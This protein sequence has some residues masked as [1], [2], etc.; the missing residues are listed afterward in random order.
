[1]PHQ[2][3]V[4]MG[5]SNS[6]ISQCFE[7]LVSNGKSISSS[8]SRINSIAVD[9][10][11]IQVQHVKIGSHYEVESES[12]IVTET[13]TVDVYNLGS[14]Q[15]SKLR[16]NPIRNVVK[17]VSQNQQ[18]RTKRAL[19]QYKEMEQK[20][21]VDDPTAYQLVNNVQEPLIALASRNHPT[22]TVTNSSACRKFLPFLQYLLLLLL[23]RL[24]NYTLF[25]CR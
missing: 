22:F 4:V 10:K 15:P 7:R 12:S 16:Q 19:K 3:L 17:W 13:R 21:K 14:I 25:Y 11:R 20:L 18:T 5:H 1:M 9:K 6:S 24:C 23:P 2:R 8:A